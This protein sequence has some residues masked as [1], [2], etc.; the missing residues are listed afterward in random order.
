[1][2]V[3]FKLRGL[4]MVPPMIFV[5]LCTWG[6][7]EK[8]LVVWGVGGV[9]FAVGLVLRV[10]SQMHLHYRLKIRKTLTTTGPYAYVR[11]PIY[12]ANTIMLGG[13]CMLAELFWF[14]PVQVL[15][16]AMIYSL[17]VRYEEA[18]LAAKYGPPYLEYR[19]AVPRWFPKWRPSQ[20]RSDMAA[21][22]SP[23]LLAEVHNLL[24]L[25]PFVV[26]ELTR[27]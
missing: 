24:Y 11:N 27:Q 2:K 6:E 12:L 17:V 1:M 22:F 9:T 16:C 7:I 21:Y 20:E 25:L 18:H 15:Y 4:L 10:W 26:K 13:A 5:A 14:V 23:S 8:E 19:A 3:I